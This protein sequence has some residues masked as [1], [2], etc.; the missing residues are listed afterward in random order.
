MDNN[1]DGEVECL[2]YLCIFSQFIFRLK[3]AWL[4]RKT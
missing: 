1:N 2:S 4:Y 3:G